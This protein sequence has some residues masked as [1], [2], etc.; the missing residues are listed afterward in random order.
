M[1]ASQAVADQ[2]D[3]HTAAHFNAI[4]IGAG[5]SGYQERA[6]AQAEPWL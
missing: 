4:I 3:T 2:E 5:I 6:F 1:T